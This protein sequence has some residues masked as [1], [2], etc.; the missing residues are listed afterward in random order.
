MYCD[1][2]V[3]N[4]GILVFLLV[5]TND[6]LCQSTW[7]YLKTSFKFHWILSIHW[8]TFNLPLI[9]S[10]FLVG[11]ESVERDK[12]ILENLTLE[13]SLVNS[14]CNSKQA[15]NAVVTAKLEYSADV[16]IGECKGDENPLC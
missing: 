6:F 5:G 9:G 13:W 16:L 14:G 4:I 15:L 10:A 12:S 1:S 8:T 7:K 3:R 2:P 11:F